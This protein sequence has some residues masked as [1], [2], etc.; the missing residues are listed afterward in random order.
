[1]HVGF[2]NPPIPEDGKFKVPS[3]PGLGLI[4]NDAELDKRRS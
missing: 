4:V 3:G 1:M 2:A